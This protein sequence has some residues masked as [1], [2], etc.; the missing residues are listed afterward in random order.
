[1]SAMSAKYRN[2]VFPARTVCCV[3]L[4][5]RGAVGRKEAMLAVPAEMVKRTAAGDGC[6][7]RVGCKDAS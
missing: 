2:V 4:E 7:F 1:M 3:S 6:C 5:L